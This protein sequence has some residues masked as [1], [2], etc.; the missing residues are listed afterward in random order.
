MTGALDEPEWLAQVRVER[1]IELERE[2]AA[3]GPEPP[4]TVGVTD[5]VDLR[6]AFFR[7]LA[8]VPVDPARLARQE[9]GREAHQRI[10]ALLGAAER[11]EVRVRDGP[12]V[13]EID[14]LGDRPTE[15]KTTGEVPDAAAALSRRPAYFEQ[16]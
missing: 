11:R 2:L 14:F 10:G 13:G 16:L 1:A 9:S 7:R 15:I 8:P 5:L 4:A 12:V 3:D 6:R